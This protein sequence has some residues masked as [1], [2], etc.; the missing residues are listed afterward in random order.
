MR[1]E[2]ARPVPA[3]RPSSGGPASCAIVLRMLGVLC[4][5]SL[6]A[7]FSVEFQQPGQPIERCSAC[8]TTSAAEVWLFCALRQEHFNTRYRSPIGHK[9]CAVSVMLWRITPP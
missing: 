7:C 6:A 4:I 3:R 8:W 5:A 2:L 9:L 1:K